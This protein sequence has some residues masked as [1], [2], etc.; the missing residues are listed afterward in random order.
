VWQATT[1]SYTIAILI[2]RFYSIPAPQFFK[3]QNRIKKFCVQTQ[4][5]VKSVERI[6]H[7]NLKHVHQIQ[8][9]AAALEK[10]CILTC[11]AGRDALLVQWDTKTGAGSSIQA[12]IPIYRN[13]NPD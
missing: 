10:S 7:R 6:S 12:F 13:T 3:S 8:Y 4:F 2:L 9:L 11:D 5:G 1:S